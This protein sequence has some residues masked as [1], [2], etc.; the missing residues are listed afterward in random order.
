SCPVILFSVALFAVI[1]IGCGAGSKRDKYSLEACRDS[2]N[3]RSRT[4]LADITKQ[5]RTRR[6]SRRTIGIIGDSIAG[7]AA[8]VNLDRRTR[9]YGDSSFW[10]RLIGVPEVWQTSLAGPL[11]DAGMPVPREH[12]G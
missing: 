6:L 3:A 11:R 4:Q 5:Q 7:T 12:S 2:L 9:V 1:A 8:S 10:T